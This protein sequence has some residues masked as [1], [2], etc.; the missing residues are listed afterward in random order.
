V[1]RLSRSLRGCIRNFAQMLNFRALEPGVLKDIDYSTMFTDDLSAMDETFAVFLNNL[2][3]DDDGRVTNPA[4]AQYRA[5]QYIRRYWDPAY[6]MERPFESWETESTWWGGDDY[7][8]T[9]QP[10]KQK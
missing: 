2:E 7:A 9:K 5:A 3:I 10:D 6:R 8:D 4:V 1:A